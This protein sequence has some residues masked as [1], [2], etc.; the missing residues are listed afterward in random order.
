MP[1]RKTVFALT[2][3]EVGKVKDYLKHNKE[4][5]Y[6]FLFEMA[7]NV[8]L[9]ISDLLPLKVSNVRGV[10]E[11]L[12]VEQKTG[13]E[14][15]V[16]LSPQMQQLI[17][18]YT[19]YMKDDDY[20]FPSRQGN[21]HLKRVRVYQ[22]FNAIGKELG[23]KESFGTHTFRRTYGTLLYKK[24]RDI[25]LV[26]RQLNHSSVTMSEIYLGIRRS[27]DKAELNKYYF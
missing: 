9:R 2:E 15:M 14:R 26:Q 10:D 24:T 5:K 27:E 19:K 3:E 22:V 11:F 16:F 8:G 4:Q 12:V 13:K 23:F 25:L 1:K 21:D 7:I 17:A 20:L 6:Q 18:E